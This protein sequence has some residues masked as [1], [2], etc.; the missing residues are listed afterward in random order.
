VP[1]AKALIDELVLMTPKV[2]DEVSF[3]LPKGFPAKVSEP[4]FHGLKAA[5]GKLRLASKT[6]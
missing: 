4:I 3:K 6:T 1:D 5:A 2:I